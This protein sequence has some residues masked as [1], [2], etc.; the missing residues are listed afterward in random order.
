[1]HYYAT[2]Y[3]AKEGTLQCKVKTLEIG[4]SEMRKRLFESQDNI[5]GRMRQKVEEEEELFVVR[6]RL[7]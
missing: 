1:M 6:W 4:R 2:L 7:L 3:P 5:E